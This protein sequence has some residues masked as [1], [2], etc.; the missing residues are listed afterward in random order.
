MI[1]NNWSEKVNPSKKLSDL[2]STYIKKG[3]KNSLLSKI[4]KA[5]FIWCWGHLIKFC[6]QLSIL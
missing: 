1:G 4:L 6:Q 2:V 5:N 3:I